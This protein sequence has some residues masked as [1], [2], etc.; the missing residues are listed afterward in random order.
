[1]ASTASKRTRTTYRCQQCGW[2]TAKWVGKCASCGEW[3][4]VTEAEQSMSPTGPIPSLT[5]DRLAT[6]I[7]DISFDTTTHDPTG[8]GE[9]DRVLG[10]GLVSGASIL[11][12]GEPGVGKSTLLL[13][14]GNNVAEQGKR[15]LFCSAEESL[16]Q[17]RMRAERMGAVSPNL[18]LAAET[19]L[20]YVL[21]QIEA[22]NPSLL[23]VDSIQ[24][25]SSADSDTL[26]GGTSQVR[27]VANTLTR[28]AKAHGFTMLIVGH[29]TK[30][31]TVA[32]P[33]TLEHLVDVVCQ[34]EGDRQGGLRFIRALKNRFGPTDELGCFEL[35]GDGIHEVPDPSS[36]FV[37]RAEEAVPGTCVTFALEGRRVLPV[38]IQALVVASSTAQPRRVTS[39]V[40]QSRVAMILAVLEKRIGLPLSN[41]DVY[42]STVGGVKLTE[43]GADLAIA[44]AVASAVRN[45]TIDH[46]VAA[47]GE[48]SL[49]GQVRTAAN[50]TQRSAEAKRLGYS[51]LVSATSKNL[52]AALHT[53][54]NAARR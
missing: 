39:G 22:T 31:G 47:F 11:V 42:V 25:L 16:G 32:G 24:T 38:E 26:P 15:V 8:I 9:F 37:A 36:L 18:Y 35:A 14:A 19:D 48:I 27:L 33:R 4:T 13:A 46:T 23:I 21:A 28:A 7:P 5:P 52:Q 43:P 53:A 2:T 44:I 20:S 6:P 41:Q 45:A 29:V 40:D 1:M 50:A 3:G 12:S 51:T 10:G 49:A 17:V 34:F 54:M 30:D